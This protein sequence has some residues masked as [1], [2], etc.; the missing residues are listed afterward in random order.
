MARTTH[1]CVVT[2]LAEIR[3]G[4]VGWERADRKLAEWGWSHR[5]ATPRQRRIAHRAYGRDRRDTRYLWVDVPVTGSPWRANREAVWRI[6]DLRRAAGTV[7]VGRL[8]RSEEVD[9]ELQPEW[10]VHEVRRPGPDSASSARSGLRRLNG[11][12]RRVSERAGLHDTGTLM[13]GPQDATRYV[14]QRLDAAPPRQ[15]LD[16]RPLDGR[17][18]SHTPQHGEDALNRALVLFCGPML[19][20]GV[21]LALALHSRP[22]G[23]VL[24]GLLA[25]ACTGSAWWTAL[26]LPIAS[27]W[28]HSAGLCVAATLPVIAYAAGVPGLH[29]GT[30]PATS[31]QLTALAYYLIGLV[32]LVRRWKWHLLT[33]G[34]L[35]LLATLTVASLPLTGHI[36]LDGYADELGLTPQETAVSGFWQLAAAVKLVWPSLGAALFFAAGW[37]ILRY[38]HFLRPGSLL[39]GLAT[40]CLLALALL[41]TASATLHSPV[42]AADGLRRAAAQHTNPPP[43]FGLEADWVCVIPTVP[44]HALDTKG[45]R[46]SPATPYLSFGDTDGSLVLWNR[47]TGAPLRIP[48]SQAATVPWSQGGEGCT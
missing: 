47:A 24:F 16:V 5:E 44:A 26:T 1:D 15:G 21:L 38:F 27:T 17:G 28:R 2:V 31:I 41:A 40:G 46:L 35:P 33:A 25:A 11:H 23:A 36:L 30:E 3:G 45:G 19:A 48:A 14:T 7:T 18:R 4:P 22:L 12:L 43:Y 9:L 42:A 20:M 8:F 32:M 34:A 13:H 6:T 37:G 29:A 10:Q 39:T